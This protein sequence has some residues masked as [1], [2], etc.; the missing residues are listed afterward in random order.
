MTP[1]SG[2]RAEENEEYRMSPP[3]H[4]LVLEQRRTRLR[5]SAGV[6]EPGV[7][8]LVVHSIS[9][10]LQELTQAGYDAV[11]LQIEGPEELSLVLR[12]K[13]AAPEV[14]ICALM[15]N[16]NKDLERMARESGADEVL[17]SEREGDQAAPP[18]DRAVAGT[19]EL[20]RRSRG[21]I[22]RSAE[23]RDRYQE[24][25][26]RARALHSSS[27]DLA[28]ISLKDLVPL[29]VED[30]VDH[31]FFMK[32]S[33]EMLKLPFPLPAMG[34]G[35]E[36]IAYLS[37]KGKFRDRSRYPM[38][39]LLLLDLHLPRIDGME[40]LRWVRSQPPLSKLVVFVL[41][42]SP[43]RR[44]LDFALQLGADCFYVKPI[45]LEALDH[46]TRVMAVRWNLIYRSHAKPKKR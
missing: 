2:F 25:T 39:T 24:L 3:R 30:D 38:P 26:S 21:L 6:P 10:A 40:V 9:D 5:S 18:L 7:V 20:I 14:P 12:I 13:S 35:E 44:D 27:F 11:F 8:S 16:L 36:A 22:A 17:P 33:F 43:L 46:I 29:L 4:V 19:E 15:P 45:G 28:Q 32:R 1:I 37:G 34:N 23:L 42:S 31:A 41:T